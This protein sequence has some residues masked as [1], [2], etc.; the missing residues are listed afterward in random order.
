MK[1]GSEK[2]LWM[3]FIDTKPQIMKATRL[4]CYWL[5]CVFTVSLQIF[6][7]I[8]EETAI[9]CLYVNK[10]IITSTKITS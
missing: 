3:T 6:I 10:N 5:Y 8:V 9:S 4:Y 1:H 2:M 7:E